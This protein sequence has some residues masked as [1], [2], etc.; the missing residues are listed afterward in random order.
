MRLS[1]ALAA[2][3]AMLSVGGVQAAASPE[4]INGVVA[5]CLAEDTATD[6]SG[7]VTD[8]SGGLAEADRDADLLNLAT[9][10]A[11]QATGPQVSPEVCGEI[12]SSIEVAADAATGTSTREQISAMASPLCD[13]STATGSVTT[14]SGYVT[15]P[16]LTEQNDST[17]N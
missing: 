12:A 9:A 2:S 7:A 15:P 10:L 13:D 4:E 5:S 6:C 14:D 3:L 17:K 1:L 11:A 16:S 8:F